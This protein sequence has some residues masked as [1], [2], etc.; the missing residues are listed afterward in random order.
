MDKI[1]S[2]VTIKPRS[3]IFVSPKR[4]PLEQNTQSCFQFARCLGT[5]HGYLYFAD[6]APHEPAKHRCQL[7]PH[8]HPGS[9]TPRPV[10]VFAGDLAPVTRSADKT[11]D[12]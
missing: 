2:S 7:R 8:S 5:G 6:P 12:K 11:T 10:A 4:R 1:Q 3:L 9:A